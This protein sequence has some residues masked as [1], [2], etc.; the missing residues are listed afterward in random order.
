MI[1]S[2]RQKLFMRKLYYIILGLSLCHSLSFG[3]PAPV[4][5]Q[6]FFL[7]DSVIEVTLTTDIR[8]LRTEKKS[9]TWQPANITMRFNDTSVISE[10]IRVEPRGVTR[11]KH[12]AILHR[13]ISNF[14]NPSSPTLS[15]LKKLKLVGGC[16]SGT[17]NEELL[18]KE[19]LVY[20][21]YNLLSV[22]SFRVRLLHV[23][24]KDSK[25]KSKTL[26]SVCFPDG[27]YERHG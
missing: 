22:M 9:P 6:Q 11:G 26:F 10:E 24:Y 13:C 2:C 25:E 23:N 7:N 18:L 3:Q 12:I 15:P 14:K 27:R 19:Y 21:I 5:S 8:K 4:N 17:V 16:R 1:F 20:K